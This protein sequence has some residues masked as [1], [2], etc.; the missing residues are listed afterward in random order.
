[1]YE[2]K[3]KEDKAENLIVYKL[4][5]DDNENDTPSA[6]ELIDLFKNC[7]IKDKH[8]LLRRFFSMRGKIVSVIV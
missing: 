1:M 2:N 8:K 5:A 6:I 7:K 4:S 3:I